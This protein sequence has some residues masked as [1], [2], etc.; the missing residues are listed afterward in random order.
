MPSSAVFLAEYIVAESEASLPVY[1][2]RYNPNV[3]Q[4]MKGDDGSVANTRPR[5]KSFEVL[6][7]LRSECIEQFCGRFLV[8]HQRFH[9][10]FLDHCHDF[11]AR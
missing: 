6:P 11:N 7:V 1:R 5:R 9:L 3:E 8:S 4:S 10:A 2:L